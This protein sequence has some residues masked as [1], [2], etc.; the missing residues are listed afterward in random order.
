MNPSVYTGLKPREREHSKLEVLEYLLKSYSKINFKV[1]KINLEFEGEFKNRENYFYK[2]IKDNF[3][4][5]DFKN[6]RV[7]NLNDWRKEINDI[8]SEEP[9]FFSCNDDHI[10][11]D[12]NLNHLE[13]LEKNFKILNKKYEYVSAAI[14]HW[15][16]IMNLFYLEKN[17]SNLLIKQRYNQKYRTNIEKHRLEEI[18][19]SNF[20]RASAIQ[21]LNKQLLKLFFSEGID[22]NHD[23]RRT[24]GINLNQKRFEN[25]EWINIFPTRELFR[26]FDVYS[27]F[28]YK[29]KFIPPMF[30]P[31]EKEGFFKLQIGGENRIQN[32]IYYSNKKKLYEFE[33]KISD[34][35]G[36]RFSDTYTYERFLPIF[37][38]QN[39]HVIE[40]EKINEKD[41]L[42]YFMENKVRELRC[43]TKYGGSYLFIFNTLLLGYPEFREKKLLLIYACLINLFDFRFFNFPFKNILFCLKIFIRNLI[44]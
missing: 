20:R 10:F 14:S 16:E 31:I 11:I 34:R 40:K 38:Q 4:N 33:K 5:L 44:K 25:I 26:H 19:I 1:S 15:Q 23:F 2:L 42:L 37:L 30:I 35:K 24:D 12:N 22:I 41:K 39:C 43:F 36:V 13:A 3:K 17:Y 9:I 7:S 28:Y 29:H 21:I 27:H 6:L 18:Y 8:K 32:A